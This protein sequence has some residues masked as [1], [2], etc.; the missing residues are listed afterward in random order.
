MKKLTAL[1]F[2]LF[3]VLAVKA[4]TVAK[5]QGAVKD[6]AGKGLASATVSLL[7]AK[8]SSLVKVAVSEAAGKF[9]FSGI[10]DGQYLISVTNVGFTKSY[11][12]AFSYTE[13]QSVEVPAI[14]LA[15]NSNNMSAVVVQAR[16]PLVEN[17]I[18][19]MVVNVDAA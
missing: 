1:L 14:T 2:I 8:D 15:A 13:S 19:K 18:D 3:T 16:R 17:K 5:I 12:A 6:E 4:Q 9:E 11:S 10:K 7:K